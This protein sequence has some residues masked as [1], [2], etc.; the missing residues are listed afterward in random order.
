M[1]VRAIAGVLALGAWFTVVGMGLLWALGAIPTWARA[2]RLGGLGCLAGMSLY[3]VVWMLGLVLGAP[4]TGTTILLVLVLLTTATLGLGRGLGRQLP[5]WST[6]VFG[7]SAYLGAA[8]IAAAGVLLEALFRAARLQGLQA[9][10]AWAFWV[11]K[12][13]ALFAFHELDEEF[14]RIL[15]GSSYP[16]LVPVL[17]A[18]S[19]HAMGE[20]DVVTLNLLY[21]VVALALVWAVAGVLADLAP[22]WLLWPFLLLAMVVPRVGERLITPQ[23]DILLDAMIVSAVLVVVLWLDDARAWQLPMLAIL[24][25]GAVTTKREGLLFA[26]CLLAAAFVATADR[27]R[28]S[29]PR[30]LAVAGVVVAT[31]L[32]W[33]LWVR[34]RDYPGEGPGG[35]LVGADGREGRAGPALR[36]AADVL[37]DD[38]LWSILPALV[39]AALALALLAREWRL[40][41]FALVLLGSGVL[42]GAWI[43]WLYPELP[44]NA[45]EATNPIV[46]YTVGVVIAGASLA[47]ILLARVW[48]R[49]EPAREGG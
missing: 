19:F 39:V 4:F 9:Y 22:P 15:P 1:T 12:S 7:R 3:G 42:G 5:E 44:L 20:I 10:D 40:G 26:A 35:G 17:N 8:G 21:W 29:W 33:R 25:A 14:F 48:R 43:V 34:A 41:S 46:R 16:P 13:E 36:L 24:L 32:P 27:V 2:L 30:L 38:G 28:R 18:T 49:A 47:P 31:A 11:P 45:N 6:P 37:F 23:A